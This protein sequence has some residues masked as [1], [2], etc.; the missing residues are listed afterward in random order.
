MGLEGGQCPQMQRIS[1][2]LVVTTNHGTGSIKPSPRLIIYHGFGPGR[3]LA[4][5]LR[6][7]S[8]SYNAFCALSSLVFRSV[9]PYNSHFTSTGTLCKWTIL[10][11]AETSWTPWSLACAEEHSSVARWLSSSVVVIK[12]GRRLV[13]HCEH[14]TP[15]LFRLLIRQEVTASDRGGG[16]FYFICS[17]AGWG[18][19]SQFTAALS[20][21]YF[22]CPWPYSDTIK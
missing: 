3:F 9:L 15:V 6:P 11:G 10:M 21:L 4:F 18:N 13:L 17:L 20:K 1:F 19:N 8:W 5:R 12:I 16:A 7:A 14:V 22:T 2:I